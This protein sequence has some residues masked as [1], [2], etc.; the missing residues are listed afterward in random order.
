MPTLKLI[1][2]AGLV[3]IVAAQ[4]W[5]Q[6]CQGNPTNEIR[7][8][9]SYGCGHYNAERKGSKG[10]HL[11]VDV[12]CRDGSEV[13]APFSGTITKVRGDFHTA[14]NVEG[15]EIQGEGFCVK[16]MFVQIAFQ[17]KN[18]R[19]RRGEVI[20]TMQNMQQMFPGIISHIHVENCD[21]SDP[22]PNLR[23]GQIVGPRPPIPRPV[24]PQQVG[25]NAVC[26]GNP[27]NKI[28]GCDRYGCGYYNAPRKHGKG[29][30]TGVDVECRDGATVFAPFS[31][32]LS[33]P[34]R[35]FNNGNAIDDGVQ[36]NGGEFCV[37]LLAIKPYTYSGYVT[38]GQRIG[39]MLPMQKVF[40]GIISHIHVE[41]CDGSDPTFQLTNGQQNQQG[42]G[43]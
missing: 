25:W 31:G 36:I 9:D 2:L 27:L 35:P 34:V 16:L 3:S 5:G 38:R 1:V 17:I 14:R 6:I 12:V 30:H 43:T 42:Q 18:G 20:G 19:V 7:G 26:A 11:A 13:R 33:G 21:H 29:K 41:N 23:R 28:R 4:Q 40:P 37:K 22:T 15:V 10:K 32:R 39:T 8:C 24:P